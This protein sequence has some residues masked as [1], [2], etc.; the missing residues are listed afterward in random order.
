MNEYGFRIQDAELAHDASGR[1]SLNE[2]K[3]LGDLLA[4][5]RRQ[6]VPLVLCTGLGLG[7]GLLK[8][9]TTP[10][11]YYAATTILVDVR[12]GDNSEDITASMPYIRNDTSLL[13]EMQVLR[14][15]TLA[16]QVV[17][18]LNLHENPA[19][20]RPP[21]SLARNLLESAKSMVRGMIGNG[22]DPVTQPEGSQQE[23]EDA[24]I[25]GA[26]VKL[27]RTI[28]IQR[29]GQSFTI[30]VSY[31]GFDPELTSQIVNAYGEAYLEDNLVANLESTERLAEWMQAR[32]AELQQ[33]AEDV[34]RRS[35]ALRA[36][37]PTD[38]LALR[39]LAQRAS[40]LDAL[41]QT[42]TE[43]YDRLAVQGSFPATNGRILTKA[44]TPKN[45]ALPKLWQ[46]VSVAT[47][48]GL[49]LGFSIAVLREMRERSFRLGEDVR[50]LTHKP[51]LGYLPR[52]PR[53]SFPKTHG[54]D[55][56]P[57]IRRQIM[58]IDPLLTLSVRDPNAL[59]GET[60]RNVHSSVMLGVSAGRGGQVIGVSSLLAG[61]GKTTLAANYANLVAGS[62]VQ[63][64][65]VD[66]DLHRT[67]LS[68]ELD[69]VERPDIMDV[70]HDKASLQEAV[71][72]V[73]ETGL[74]VLPCTPEQQSVR[75][76]DML[77]RHN[78]VS[79][80]AGLRESYDLVILDLPPLGTVVDTKIIHAQIDGIILSCA[81]GDTPRALVRDYLRNEP[82]VAHKILGVVL[83]KVDMRGLRKFARPGAREIYIEQEYGYG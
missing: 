1:S 57:G 6:A 33:S 42:L 81:W 48:L 83:N 60:L 49:M 15:L 30:D 56:I 20:T 36:E 59:F 67:T 63:T 11:Q 10:E 38:V 29:I 50:A 65:L 66:L 39:E 23:R 79:L 7:L 54:V 8:H 35:E 47:I 73:A 37:Q 82:E 32:I 61:E 43:R 22:S 41:H 45:A 19:F 25:Q 68:Q 74:E 76:S 4:A 62:G 69:C 12:A 24:A 3:T 18:E 52:V 51:F 17:R 9:A 16:E 27:Q 70:L 75:R 71:R 77:L 46:S 2:A 5:L 21:T 31:V 58:K 26:A 72:T 34:R 14:S 40:N 53:K 78:I 64:L 44:V 13:N 80:I 55:P 28:G